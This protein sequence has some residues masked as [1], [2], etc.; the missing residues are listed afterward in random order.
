MPR[1]ELETILSG[2]DWVRAKAG[3]SVRVWQVEDGAAGGQ[4]WGRVEGRGYTV[5]TEGIGG[6]AGRGPCWGLN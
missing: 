2:E 6:T 5:H 3:K 1:D 4:S